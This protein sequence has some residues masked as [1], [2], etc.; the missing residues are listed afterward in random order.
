MVSLDRFCVILRS[1][2]AIVSSAFRRIGAWLYVI[3][4]SNAAIVSSAFRRIGA[5]LYVIL[6][7]NAAIVFPIWS[8]TG[9]MCECVIRARLKHA[10][11][12]GRLMFHAWLVLMLVSIHF[13]SLMLKWI[14]V[15]GFLLY[16]FVCFLSFLFVV[17]YFSCSRQCA[18]YTCQFCPNVLGFCREL[19]LS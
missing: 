5:W 11:G 16:N 3:L 7:S 2:A 4:L 14:F 17:Q 15:L 18:R 10:F 12:H 6:L 1:N 19:L 8:M 13:S 9:R